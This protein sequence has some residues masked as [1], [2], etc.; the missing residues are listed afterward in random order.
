MG[1]S[2]GYN[3]N[4]Y[5]ISDMLLFIF[6]IMHNM[7]WLYALE[8]VCASYIYNHVYDVLNHALFIFMMTCILPGML[9]ISWLYAF[10]HVDVTYMLY[11]LPSMIRRPWL[12]IFDHVMLF[13]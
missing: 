5:P 13:E 4:S 9:Y 8:H 6:S 2:F 10:D 1:P 3:L 12:N 7:L 11:V